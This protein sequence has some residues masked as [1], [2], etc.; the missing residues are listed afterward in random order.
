MDI[1]LLAMIYAATEWK[2]MA[3]DVHWLVTFPCFR[4]SIMHP[5]DGKQEELIHKNIRVISS[6]ASQ[7]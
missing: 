4:V 7:T 3:Q 5:D 6:T 1:Y 2:T